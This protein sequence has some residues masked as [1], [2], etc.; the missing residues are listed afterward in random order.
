MAA[1]ATKTTVTANE[2]ISDETSQKDTVSVGGVQNVTAG[3]AEG[4]SGDASSKPEV[5][6]GETMDDPEPDVTQDGNNKNGTTVPTRTAVVFLGPYHRYSRGDTACFDTE[7]AKEL[8][9][10]RIAVWPEDAKDTPTPR[11]G[12]HDFD[13][14]IG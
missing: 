8:V 6:T 12:E 2:K 1:K 5:R 11:K 9:G 3:T 13:L 14:D 7:Y 10:R 4:D